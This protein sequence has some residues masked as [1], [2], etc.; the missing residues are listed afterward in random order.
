MINFLDILFGVFCGLFLY[1]FIGWFL[2]RFRVLV[3]HRMAFNRI[4]RLNRPLV[5]K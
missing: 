4:S 5:N 1:D 3:K 2:S